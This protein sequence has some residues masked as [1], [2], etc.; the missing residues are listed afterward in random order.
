MTPEEEYSVREILELDKGYTFSETDYDY[1]LNFKLKP[2]G[3]SIFSGFYSLHTYFYIVTLLPVSD[4]A[5][6]I[7]PNPLIGQGEKVRLSMIGS[8]VESEDH[9]L[10]N[11]SRYTALDE[12]TECVF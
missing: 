5:K 1:E 8:A 3:T 9:T 12:L 6:R 4:L 10:L 11:R 7:T 2:H